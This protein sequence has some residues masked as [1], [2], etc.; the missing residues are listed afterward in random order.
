MLEVLVS[1]KNEEKKIALLENGNLVEYY[2]DNDISDR[3]EG[4]IY[5][6]QVKDI[7]K[8]M[9]SAF[10]DIGI[11]KNSFIHL[12]DILPKVDE[13]KTEK[14]TKLNIEDVVKVNQKI[15]VQIKKDSNA[16][17]GARVSTYKYSK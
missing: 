8:G 3:K 6:G 15:L 1:K 5:L 16:Q 2:E 4:N 10:V 11:G 7:V 12:K 9:Q 17:K 14:E 13:T